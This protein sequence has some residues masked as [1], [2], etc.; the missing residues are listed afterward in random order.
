KEALVEAAL[1]LSW[2]RGLVVASGILNIYARD[3]MATANGAAALADAYP[4][5][6][7]LGIGVSHKPAVEARGS[8]YA[9]PVTTMRAYLDAMEATP[10]RAPAPAEPAPV[11]LAAL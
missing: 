6:F 7:L 10:Y 5:R 4:G 9:K 2:S 3:A 8:R 1:L 11:V